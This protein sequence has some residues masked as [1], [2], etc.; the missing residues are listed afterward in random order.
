MIKINNVKKRYANGV[1]AL[2]GLSVDIDQGEF[3]FIIGPSGAGKS[4]LIKT[5]YCEEKVDSGSIYVS[6]K[7]I[8]KLKHNQVPY[9][10]R[11][12]G[13]V[14]QDFKLLKDQ[15]VYQ[16][17]AF[18][19]EVTGVHH[20]DIREKT[21]NA[22]KTVGLRHKAKMYP[23]ELSGGEQQ[24]VAIA[25]GI[26]REPRLLICDEPTG[27]LDPMISEEIMNTLSEVNRQGMTILMATHD[28]RV[29][30][31]YGHRVITIVGGQVSEDRREGGYT[32][33]ESE[34]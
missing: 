19:L 30:N 24:R 28:T 13:I 6:K 7:D 3:V 4:T 14:F 23:D 8:T 12:I 17:V 29:V 16:N 15:T 32:L 25:R 11:Q 34:Y 21:M 18:A 2:D 10:R 5:L 22:L 31:K 20:K 33:H 26:V 1:I 27:N 9:Y